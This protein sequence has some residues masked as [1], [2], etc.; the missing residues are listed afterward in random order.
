VPLASDDAQ[1][2][3]VAARLVRDTGCEPVVVGDLA[4]ATSFQ[5]GGPGFRA[6]TAAPELRRLLGLPEGTRSRSARRWPAMAAEASEPTS[7][8][9]PA[10]ALLRL[11][12]V[13]P[14]EVPALAW[15]YL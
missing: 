10:Q 3:Q 6:N 14:D 8:R 15:S 2:L 13:R 4:K 12:G 7:P 9:R 5:R 11:L 1:T